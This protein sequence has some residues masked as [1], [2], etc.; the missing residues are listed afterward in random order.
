MRWRVLA[1]VTVAFAL[2][3]MSA[4]AVAPLSPLLRD[5]LALTRAQVG[6]FIPA[7]YLGG[8]S[9]SLLAGW[10][11]DHLGVRP[12][13]ALGQLLTGVMVALAAASPTL[14][15][16]LAALVGAGFGFA[17]VNPATGRAIVD[18][19]PPRQ[20]G[21]AMGIKQT[22]LTLGGVVGALGLPPLALALGWRGALLAAGGAAIASSAIVALGYR[23]P[24]LA[25]P[26]PSA[27]SPRWP[28]LA[29][30][31]RRP[32]VMVVFACGFALSI[33]QSAVLAYFALYVRETFLVSA[34]VAGQLL[35]L[36]Q[37]GGTASRLGWGFLSDWVFAGR[38]R[39]GVVV[40]ALGGAGAYVL[41]ALGDRLPFPAAIA[42]ALVAGAGAFGWVGLYFTLIAEIGGA[43]HAGVLT[44]VAVTFTWS[45]VLVGPLLFGGVLAL[46]GG[47]GAAWLLL[48]ALAA[49]SALVLARLRPLVQ[50]GAVAEPAE[51][52]TAGAP[53]SGGRGAK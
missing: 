40:S 44:G 27:G 14:P 11:V 17:V 45:G 19:F 53:A 4:L 31:V 26:A 5:A 33:A 52:D 47:Y 29:S 28:E 24:V 7:V 15:L 48:A 46:T 36:A 32:G 50:R 38:R 9:M 20:R 43:R 41:F 13:L 37:V 51:A 18:W 39:V 10:L 12:T 22:G 8:V 30:L 3:A 49:V 1:L 42:L 34:I 25:R 2:S 6:L 16:M 23:R 21:V 35:A